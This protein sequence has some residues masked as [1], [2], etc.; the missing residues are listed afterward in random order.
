MQSLRDARRLTRLVLVWFALALGAA[1]ASPLVKP[2]GLQLVC[3]GTAVK[4]VAG[5]G[6]GDD[7]AAPLGLDC[8][9]CGGGAVPLPAAP[10][11]PLVLTDTTRPQAPAPHGHMAHCQPPLPARGPPA[12]S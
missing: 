3:S 10:D 8:P 11:L 1:V 4:L 6:D 9:L 5:S 7:R 12:L 2:E